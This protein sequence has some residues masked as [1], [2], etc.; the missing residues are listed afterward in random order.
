MVLATFRTPLV[1]KIMR[2]HGLQ[3]QQQFGG[4]SALV[5]AANSAE[6]KQRGSAE[7]RHNAA[8]P[9]GD[10]RN[11]GFRGDQGGGE[12]DRRHL[13]RIL[14]QAASQSVRRDRLQPSAQT[15]IYRLILFVIGIFALTYLGLGYVRLT[16]G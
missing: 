13:C 7:A 14:F 2:R 16:L 9:L 6:T 8:D 11:V 15:S 1:A 3:R 4:P 12:R 10:G 5:I